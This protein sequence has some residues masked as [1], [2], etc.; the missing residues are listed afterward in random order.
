MCYLYGSV[1]KTDQEDVLLISY[2]RLKGYSNILQNYKIE[3]N[4]SQN[5]NYLYW[6]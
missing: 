1:Q 4:M 5:K 6:S 3:K 2:L